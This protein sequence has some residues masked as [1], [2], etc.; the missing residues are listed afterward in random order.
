MKYF[1]SAYILFFAS[2]CSGEASLLDSILEPINLQDHQGSVSAL[3]TTVPQEIEIPAP[4]T[5]YTLRTEAFCEALKV[6]MQ[7]YYQITQG[8]LNVDPV[9]GWHELNIPSENW[10]FEIVQF[11]SGPLTSKIL[12]QYRIHSGGQS[13][14]PYRLFA[15]CEL[16]EDVYVVQQRLSRGDALNENVIGRE[17]VDVL[18]LAHKPVPVG[19]VDLASHELTQTLSSGSALLW[20][21]LKRRPTVSKGKVIDIMAEE[22]SLQIRMK[23]EVLQDGAKGELVSVRNL[24]S[25]KDFKAEIVDENTA[26]IY[27]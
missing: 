12:L 6:Q 2:L 25:R 10:D 4:R 23:A 17:R 19:S 16:W 8:E 26:K 9:Q 22:G 3:N 13:F 11:P 21:D 15:R 24:N 27:F 14:G 5:V 1:L 18:R 7:H 20:R